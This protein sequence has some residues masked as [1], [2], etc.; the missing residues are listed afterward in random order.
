LA[1]EGAAPDL[2]GIRLVT[3]RG[4]VTRTYVLVK[5]KGGVLGKGGSYGIVNGKRVMRARRMA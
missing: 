4:I 2:Q 5:K 1:E 3:F